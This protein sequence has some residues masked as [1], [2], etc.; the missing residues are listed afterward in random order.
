MSQN[1][2]AELWGEL[3]LFSARRSEPLRPGSCRRSQLHFR[4]GHTH[5]M[6]LAQLNVGRLKAPIDDPMIDDFRTNLAWI[7]SLAEASPG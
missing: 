4:R 2:S 7:N 1:A 5:G 6:H 3:P